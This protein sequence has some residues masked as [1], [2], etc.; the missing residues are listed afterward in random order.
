MKKMKNVLVLILFIC[1]LSFGVLAQIGES[2]TS[3]DGSFNGQGVQAE[4]DVS[5]K[6]QTS[7]ESTSK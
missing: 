7:E 2:S 5:S 3:C 1:S 6:Q 4:V